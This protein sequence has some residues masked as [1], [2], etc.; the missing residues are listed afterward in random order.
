MLFEITKKSPRPVNS[1]LTPATAAIRGIPM[2]ESA[3]A[4][5]AELADG[6]K[7]FAG[8]MTRPSVVG[9]PVLGDIVY[10]GRLELPFATGEEGTYE[11][12]EEVVAEGAGYLSADNTVGVKAN[13][14]LKTPISFVGGLFAVEATGQFYE[15]TLVELPTPD[16]AGNVRAR[17]RVCPGFIKAAPA[18]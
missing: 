1:L 14:P 12:A 4:G 6:T 10:P 13:T 5:T 9:G 3:T 16:I 11:F 15:F 7:P 17:F 8:F 2:Q 18:A